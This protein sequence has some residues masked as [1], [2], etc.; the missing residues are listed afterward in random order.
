[1][2]ITH[3]P[4]RRLRLS[5]SAPLVPGWPGTDNWDPGHALL[6]YISVPP[7][8]FYEP[9]AS[10]AHGR[11]E[12]ELMRAVLEDALL[13]FQKGLVHQGRRVQRLAREAEAWLFSDDDSW[14]FRSCPFARCWG[15]NRSIS[16]GGSGAGAKAGPPP[17]R[18]NDCA[19]WQDSG[20]SQRKAQ[21]RYGVPAEFCG[22]PFTGQRL[23]LGALQPAS[24]AVTSHLGAATTAP[25]P[26]ASVSHLNPITALTKESGQRRIAMHL[27]WRQTLAMLVTV[28]A[29]L[30]PLGATPRRPPFLALPWS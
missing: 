4:T 30:G 21:T 29:L 2:Q 10:L 8:Q 25:I 7:A 11:P 3:S 20:G 19:Y 26:A 9:R 27:T 17:R 16:D 13:C 14:P 18:R 5:Q 12:A 28:G 6:S 22:M 15:W 23:P 1:M 24:G